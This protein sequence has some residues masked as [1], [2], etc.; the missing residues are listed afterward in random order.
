MDPLKGL[1]KPTEPFSEKGIEMHKI[2]FV[3]YILIHRKPIMLKHTSE[4][5]KK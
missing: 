2:K 4:I 1:A 5:I 3:S